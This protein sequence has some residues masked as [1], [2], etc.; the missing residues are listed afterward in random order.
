MKRHP[1]GPKWEALTE[2]V[3]EAQRFIQRAEEAR[4]AVKTHEYI[5]P[6]MRPG[7]WT[8]QD[9]VTYAAAKRASMDLTRALA[10]LRR[11]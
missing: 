4:D 8:E 9:G 3:V 10:R 2:A 11:A 5:G 6:D 1:N 7:W